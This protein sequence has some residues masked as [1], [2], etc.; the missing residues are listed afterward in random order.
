MINSTYDK[1]F[2]GLAVS[3]KN[4]ARFDMLIDFILIYLSSSL[5]FFLKNN[6]SS[7]SPSVICCREQQIPLPFPTDI[8]SQEDMKRRR[9]CE[10][11]QEMFDRMIMKNITK[12]YRKCHDHDGADLEEEYYLLMHALLLPTFGA[13]E[14]DSVHRCDQ[15][16][17]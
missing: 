12:Y 10:K 13:T 8:P 15:D 1:Y 6:C 9:A 16:F 11:R 14:K 3:Q 2:R 17:Y 5:L 7:P 4:M